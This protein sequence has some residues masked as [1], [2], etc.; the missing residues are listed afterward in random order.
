[1][2]WVQQHHAGLILIGGRA[3][4]QLPTDLRADVVLPDGRL[5]P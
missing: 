3:V 1:M 4:A 5:R 2:Q